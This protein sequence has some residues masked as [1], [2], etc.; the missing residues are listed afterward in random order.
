[1]V[2]K[3]ETNRTT[4][5]IERISDC[6]PK[7]NIAKTAFWDFQSSALPTELPSQLRLD[8]KPC[9]Q[10]AGKVKHKQTRSQVY[11]SPAQLIFGT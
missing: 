1:M 10:P 7:Q 5:N 11:A 9:T 2:V 3:V 4:V 6:T 8:I